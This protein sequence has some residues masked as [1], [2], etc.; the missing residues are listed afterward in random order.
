MTD[1][2]KWRLNP[3]VNP[4][5]NRKITQTGKVYKKL[6][7]QCGPPVAVPDNVSNG[8]CDEWHVNPNINPRTHRAIKR[9][10]KVFKALEKECG[11]VID[12]RTDDATNCSKQKQIKKSQN[13]CSK[14]SSSKNVINKNVL[15]T[16]AKSVQT[17]QMAPVDWFSTRLATALR[18]IENVKRI[19]SDQWDMCM[20]GAKAKRFASNFDNVQLIGKGTFGQVFLVKLKGDELVIKEAYMEK[21]EK[22]IMKRDVSRDVKWNDIPKNTYPSEYDFM[23]AVSNLVVERKCPNFIMAFNLAVC[24]SCRVVGLFGDTKLSVKNPSCYAVFMESAC[25]DMSSLETHNEET[26]RSVFYQLLIALHAIHRMGIYHSDIKLHNILIS[27]IKPGGLFNYVLGKESYLVQ[28]CGAFVMLADFGVAR[29]LTPMTN[30]SKYYGSRHAKVV[31]NANGIEVFQPFTTRYTFN[32]SGDREKSIP[33]F[34]DNG[35]ESTENYFFK[36]KDSKPSIDVDLLDTTSFPPFE[37]FHD[38]QDVVRMFTGGYNTYRDGKHYP[39]QNL[40]QDFKSELMQHAYMFQ[41]NSFRVVDG[42]RYV[43]ADIMLR[44]MYKLPEQDVILNT[45]KMY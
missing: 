22:R 6:V 44:K 19:E 33:L 34:W 37:F 26:Q 39:M 31:T 4:V 41:S 28:N 15:V 38:I 8:I 12:R 40:N 1:C 43:R 2:E 29:Y 35:V 16:L 25:G 36:G 3:N 23:V 5:T 7:K 32:G 24:D 17:S 9:E 10:G 45:F 30:N 18:I 13:Y 20:S 42:V 11:K 27:L 14:Q 21:G